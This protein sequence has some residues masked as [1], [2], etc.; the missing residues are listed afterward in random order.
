M[1]TVMTT[2]RRNSWGRKEEE[3]M[4]IEGQRSRE[5]PNDAT[6]QP[7]NGGAQLEAE[8][9]ALAERWRQANGQHDNRQSSGG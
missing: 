9:E 5:G 8:A 3:N 4:A 7:T 2:I 1:T 6:Q